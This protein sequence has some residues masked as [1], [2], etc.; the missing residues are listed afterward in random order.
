MFITCPFWFPLD[1]GMDEEIA[2][3]ALSECLGSG[4]TAAGQSI[5]VGDSIQT[6]PLW[7]LWA[8]FIVLPTGK[9]QAAAQGVCIIWGVV[10][11]LDILFLLW[12]LTYECVYVCNISVETVSLFQIHV[13]LENQTPVSWLAR[14]CAFTC[15]VTSRA[16]EVS[17]FLRNSLA[18]FPTTNYYKIRNLYWDWLLLLVYWD[19]FL[20]AH[21]GFWTGNA[22]N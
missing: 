7:F 19:V 13:S 10:E 17:V 18:S 15:R 21:T 4:H 1:L 12:V 11:V 6:V 22:L 9:H 5:Y 14:Q 20:M 2:N 16:P 8:S 3:G